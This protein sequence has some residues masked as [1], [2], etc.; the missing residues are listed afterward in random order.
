MLVGFHTRRDWSA[1][2]FEGGIRRHREKN[3]KNVYEDLTYSRY[4]WRGVA[5]QA[6]IIKPDQAIH[7]S[8]R[9][10]PPDILAFA[11]FSSL[12][13]LLF[14]NPASHGFYIPHIC[15]EVYPYLYAY[16]VHIFLYLCIV[17]GSWTTRR[18]LFIIAGISL[19]LL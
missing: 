7:P 1:G 5:A 8:R 3:N 11:I 6:P 2:T 10:I 17:R 16:I 4:V 13:M 9:I 14:I 19:V 12:F 15:G 18:K